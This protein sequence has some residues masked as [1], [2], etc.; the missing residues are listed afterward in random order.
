[1]NG[2]TPEQ[3]KHG[4]S[5]LMGRGKLVSLSL[6]L[7]GRRGMRNGMQPVPVRLAD[8]FPS[9]VNGVIFDS[10]ITSGLPP[11]AEIFIVLRHVSNVP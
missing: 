2:N 7:F 3:K 4:Q 11:E 9:W 1:M 8:R 5:G 10:A 6:A